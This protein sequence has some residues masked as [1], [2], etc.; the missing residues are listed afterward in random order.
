VAVVQLAAENM[1]M[2]CRVYVTVC[3]ALLHPF[4][5][6]VDLSLGVT[7]RYNRLDVSYGDGDGILSANDQVFSKRLPIRC[8]VGSTLL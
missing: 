1:V 8:R 2:L 5:I 3:L 4:R 7:G 6:R